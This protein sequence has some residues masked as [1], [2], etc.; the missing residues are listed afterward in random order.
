MSVLLSR[1][2]PSGKGTGLQILYREFESHRALQIVGQAFL[3]VLLSNL[4]GQTRMSPLLRSKGG[5]E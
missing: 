5:A 3:P 2:S 4:K 1:A